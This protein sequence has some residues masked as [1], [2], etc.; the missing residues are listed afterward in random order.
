M[1]HHQHAISPPKE[2]AMTNCPGTTDYLTAALSPD[3][4][5]R[6]APRSP[7]VETPPDAGEIVA[8]WAEAGPARWFAKDPEFDRQFRTRFLALHE[9]AA[10]GELDAWRGTAEGALALLILLDQ[11]PRN[12]FR[13]AR[14]MYVTDVRARAEADTAIRAGHDRN[15]AF[16]QQKFFYLPFAHSEDLGDQDRAVALCERLGGEDYAHAQG[17]RDIVRRFGRFPHRNSIL[18]RAMSP[19]EQAF[20]DQGGYAG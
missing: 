16:E 9:A 4:P 18:G 13:G 14:R 11:F 2:T 12:A 20:L 3:A 7:A 17:H 19:A 5:P 10:R 15:V 6:R 8:F 1:Q